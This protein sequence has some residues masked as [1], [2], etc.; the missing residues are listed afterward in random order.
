[1]LKRYR[2]QKTRK[3]IIFLRRVSNIFKLTEVRSKFYLS[4]YIRR[5]EKE[6]EEMEVRNYLTCASNIEIG[7]KAREKNLR[8][9]ARIPVRR[10]NSVPLRSS[11]LLEYG[12]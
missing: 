3:E 4:R 9:Q 10:S 6:E 8:V 12:H 11:S 5:Q 7:N 2:R 1:M